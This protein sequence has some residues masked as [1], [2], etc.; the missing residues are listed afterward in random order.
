MV[1]FVLLSLKAIQC[2]QSGGRPEVKPQQAKGEDA[3][4][5]G[6][7]RETPHHWAASLRL[8]Q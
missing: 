8:Q 7:S 3:Q 1:L 2:S 6:Q 5:G 4:N